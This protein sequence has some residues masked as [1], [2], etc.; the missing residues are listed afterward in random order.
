MDEIGFNISMRSG[1][2]RSAVGSPDVKIVVNVQRK[3]V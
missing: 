2:G 1:F 3:N